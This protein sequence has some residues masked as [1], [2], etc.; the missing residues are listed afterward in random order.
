MITGIPPRIVGSTGFKESA[1][2]TA[3]PS[4][5]RCTLGVRRYAMTQ[6][7]SGGMPM[8]YIGGVFAT[9]PHWRL[10]FALRIS[11][12][13]VRCDCRTGSTGITRSLT[14]SVLVSRSFASVA[15]TTRT[16]LSR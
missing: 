14:R 7:Q 6:V 10:C 3:A 9:P 12:T 5:R 15:C 4:S 11:L 13:L 8:S 16:S 1:S 2:L